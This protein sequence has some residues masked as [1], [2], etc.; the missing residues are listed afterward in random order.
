M[1]IL[2]MTFLFFAAQPAA[3]GGTPSSTMSSIQVEY[4]SL[5]KCEDAKKINRENLQRASLILATCTKK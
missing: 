3:A 1:Y 5:E 2:A 4:T